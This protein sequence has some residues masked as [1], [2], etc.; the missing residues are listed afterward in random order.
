MGNK[1]IFLHTY[2]VCDDVYIDI[3][4]NFAK[5]LRTGALKRGETIN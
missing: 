3:F 4:L 5:I 2:V 1:N